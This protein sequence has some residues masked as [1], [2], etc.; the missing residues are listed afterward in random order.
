MRLYT[1]GSR[2]SRELKIFLETRLISSQVD[3]KLKN[4]GRNTLVFKGEIS[5]KS[6]AIEAIVE[7]VWWRRG[8]DFVGIDRGF[9]F[10]TSRCWFQLQFCFRIATILA[11]IG[12]R[13][14]SWSFV[15][16]HPIKWRR[17]HHVSSPIAAR[18]RLDRT[19]IVE[20]F[21]ESS[22]PSDWSSGEVD[23]PISIVW[24]PLWWRS[25]APRVATWRQVSHLIASLKL[26]IKHVLDLVI[27]WTRVHAINV[28]TVR[29]DA[30]HAST[31]PAR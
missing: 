10:A 22:W 5:P 28:F 21:H 27:A 12:P 15:D 23:G 18:S 17:F 13:S 4:K 1:L 2:G 29:S 11:T 9:N 31:S 30:R 26:Y 20:F 19:A 3:Q 14:W 16:R 24:Y 8:G 7:A 25:G 6:S